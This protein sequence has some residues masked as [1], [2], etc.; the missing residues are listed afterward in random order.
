MALGKVVICLNY[1]EEKTEAKRFKQTYLDG[2]ERLI[3][4]KNAEASL[5]RSDYVKN[6][7]KNQDM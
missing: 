5:K 2:L 1:R 6:I 7:F 3:A 4:V